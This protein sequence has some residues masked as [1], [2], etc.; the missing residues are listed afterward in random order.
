MQSLFGSLLSQIEY[1][2]TGGKQ[3][4][5]EY[6]SQVNR[7]M[8]KILSKMFLSSST[9]HGLLG[10]RCRRLHLFVSEAIPF[11]FF[12]FILRMQRLKLWVLI[13]ERWKFRTHFQHHPSF[14]IRRISLDKPFFCK[15]FKNLY[16]KVLFLDFE[17]V[18]AKSLSWC[19]W[20]EQLI[21]CV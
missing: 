21:E 12:F 3:K 1:Y 17:S 6:F 2:S 13:D 11:V 14:K 4:K 7:L 10:T 18:C 16:S 9:Q 15:K 8:W 5:T 20:Y 19:N